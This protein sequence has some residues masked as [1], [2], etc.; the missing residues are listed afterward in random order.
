M[1]AEGHHQEIFPINHFEHE[2]QLPLDGRLEGKIFLLRN[3]VLQQVDLPL[4]KAGG[5][6]PVAQGFSSST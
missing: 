3:F 6:E 2:V 5:D 4:G 1:P